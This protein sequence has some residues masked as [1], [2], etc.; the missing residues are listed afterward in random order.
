MQTQDVG[1]RQLKV[2]LEDDFYRQKS[3]C[4]IVTLSFLIVFI[5]AETTPYY[6][7]GFVDMNHTN[8]T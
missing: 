1:G 6:V 8:Y 5:C 2:S 4:V 3:K 7:S